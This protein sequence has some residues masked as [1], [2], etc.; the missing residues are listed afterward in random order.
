MGI[1][2]YSVRG[3]L[4]ELDFRAN[5][6]VFSIVTRQH[7]FLLFKNKKKTTI[8]AVYFDNLGGREP[9][10]E[11]KGDGFGLRLLNYRAQLPEPNK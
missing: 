10:R 5:C 1:L 8:H 3:T 7:V 6:G 9:E 11:G 2:E 4:Y